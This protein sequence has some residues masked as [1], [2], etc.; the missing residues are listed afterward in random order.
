MQDRQSL[1]VGLLAVRRQP[2]PLVALAAVRAR[3]AYRT[4]RDQVLLRIVAGM[5]AE[6]PVV[7]LKIQHRTASLTPPAVAKEPSRKRIYWC[8]LQYD[9][10]SS[11]K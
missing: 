10:G 3:V 4:Q 2:L 8:S 1:I 7:H 5:A 6:F 11:R 9:K